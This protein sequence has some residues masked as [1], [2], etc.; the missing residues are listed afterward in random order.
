MQSFAPVID[1][2]AESLP[3]SGLTWSS[4]SADELEFMRRVYDHHVDRASRRRPFIADLPASNLDTVEGRHQLR[5]DAARDCRLLLVEIRSELSRQQ[6]QG[7][8][9]AQGVRT[10]GVAS[11]YRSASRQF[12][13]WQSY[14]PRYFQDTQSHRASLPGGELGDRAVDCMV[15]Y[16]AARIAAPGYSLHNNGIA[17]DL[18]TREDGH[19][20]GAN[21][22]DIPRWQ[23]SWLFAWLTANA[24]RFNFY[25][26]T[27]INEPWHWE[28]RSTN[29]SESFAI[30]AHFEGLQEAVTTP[31]GEIQLNNTPLLSSHRGT[32]PD[33]VLRWN[34]FQDT[35]TTIDIVVHLHGYGR[36]RDQMRLVD[37]KLPKSG[38]DFS[39]PDNPSDLILGRSRPTLAIL[40]RGNYFGGRSNTGYNF[41]ALT[42]SN[43]LEQLITYAIDQFSRRVGLAN[44]RRDRLILT[45]HSGGGAAL[46]SILSHN[47]IA[48]DEIY[49]F[50]GLYTSNPAPLI[51]WL[52][53]RISIDATALSTST[54]PTRYMR[55]QGGALCVLYIPCS[56]NPETRQLQDSGTKVGSEAVQRAITTALT[57]QPSLLA[58]YYRVEYTSIG[59][60][61][62][63][64][65]FGW[66]LLADAA[67]IL[68]N[69][70]RLGG[71]RRFPNC[72]S[73]TSDTF[74][75][76]DPPHTQS[77][78]SS[79]PSPLMSGGVST[80]FVERIRSLTFSNA[81]DINAYFTRTAQ[82]DFVDWFNNRIAQRE[83]W[84]GLHL[85][86]IGRSSRD[87]IRWVQNSLNQLLGTG[88]PVDGINGQRTQAA[89][90]TFQSQNGIESDGNVGARTEAA[91]IAAGASPPRGN[92]AVKERF[93]RIW[94]AIPIMFDA[95]SINLMQFLCLMSI[96]INE[97]GGDLEPTAE[98]VGRGRPGHPGIAYAFDRIPNLKR[99]YN[100][101]GNKTALELFNDPAFLNAHGHLPLAERLRNT[102]DRRWA[103]DRYPQEDYPTSADPAI[104]GFILE[105]DFYKFR[106]RGLIQTTFRGNYRGIIQYIQAHDLEHP[107]IREYRQRWTGLNSDHIAT[108]STNQDWD[109]L[110]QET[111]YQISA[112]AIRL[113]SRHNGY[114]NLPLNAETL[115]G[116]GAGSIYNVGYRVSGGSV[117]ADRFR[118]RVLQIVNSLDS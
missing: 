64:R 30:V 107:V 37:D 112:I 63:P 32:Q 39:N 24:S 4:A 60:D 75:E 84:R 76:I 111:D 43:G 44:L 98:R 74:S 40:P 85:G 92:S 31:R 68:P 10:I 35:P 8:A 53:T 9:A 81:A 5:S 23:R 101:G 80:Q 95:P 36:A 48:I 108:T 96:M 91:L 83:N 15:G 89:V 72:R 104:T 26:N 57:N 13:L 78:P 50:D 102:T 46:L 114:L 12:Q 41:P 100:G 61:N 17:V 71:N 82:L 73:N 6:A 99:S 77:H 18:T 2:N 90:R 109:R 55:E 56:T 59:H 106:G 118:R 93:T 42:S 7:V 58:H 28:Y 79:Q 34:D 19:T 29:A 54:D 3:S 67:A 65:R 21:S 110:F 52:G 69:T 49:I 20:L 14:F 66:R 16:V 94:N 47:T 38:L 11:G 88:L 117:Y 115:N 116:S 27:S 62:I 103:G 70:T 33:L 105:A 113:H 25:Q 51:N 86:Q 97:T 45:A 1:T 22:R 87:Y